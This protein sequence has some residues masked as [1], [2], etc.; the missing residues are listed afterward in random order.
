MDRQLVHG[1]LDMQFWT[2]IFSMEITSNECLTKVRSLLS[3]PFKISV[4]RSF[5]ENEAKT[6]IDFLDRVSEWRV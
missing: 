1:S 3:C 2:D 4:A 5:R 6:F